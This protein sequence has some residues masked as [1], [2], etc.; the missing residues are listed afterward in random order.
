MEIETI[1]WQTKKST[2]W[3]NEAIVRGLKYI[4]EYKPKMKGENMWGE[5]MCTLD[6]IIILASTLFA[7]YMHLCSENEV[8]MFADPE[9]EQRI[10]ELEQK[11]K[12]LEEKD[13]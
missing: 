10:R 4:W 13:E 11:V 9:Y 8:K 5:L 1:S 6:L 12:E 3:W 7:Y 2:L